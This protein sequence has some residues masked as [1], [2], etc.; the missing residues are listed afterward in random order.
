MSEKEAIMLYKD[1]I[2]DHARILSYLIDGGNFEGAR[3]Y[4]QGIIQDA[5]NLDE[6]LK[7]VIE[8]K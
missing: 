4:V 7:K 2:V 5:Q 3:S 1:S 6:Y 8:S